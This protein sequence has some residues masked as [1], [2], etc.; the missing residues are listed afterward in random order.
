MAAIQVRRWLG[1]KRVM[2]ESWQGGNG[3]RSK[4]G[5]D[6]AAAAQAVAADRTA[7]AEKEARHAKGEQQV[8]R[9]TTIRRG[10]AR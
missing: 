4:T 6:A 1:L 7:I 10:R 8:E 5:M 9:M 2:V 3:G